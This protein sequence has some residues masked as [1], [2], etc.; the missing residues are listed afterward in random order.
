MVV[1][2]YQLG[3][4]FAGRD[5]VL[6]AH[7]VAEFAYL[8]L[9]CRLPPRPDVLA[10]LAPRLVRAVE[11]DDRQNA[12]RQQIEQTVEERAELMRQRMMV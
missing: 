9:Q 3:L 10:T 5:A 1:E 7:R 6:D 12:V 8:L 11:H 2:A 4:S